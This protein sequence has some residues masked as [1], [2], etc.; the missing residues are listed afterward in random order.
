MSVP[1]SLS[2]GGIQVTLVSGGVH[3]VD[4]G[5]MM[6]ILP[7]GLWNKWYPADEENRIWLENHCLVVDT[8]GRRLLVESGCGNK[9]GE[10]ERRFYG[11]ENSDWI[12]ANLVSAGFALDSFDQVILTHLHTDH[13][14][15]VVTLDE[16]GCEVPTFPNAEVFVSRQELH[17]ANKGIGITPTAY[18]RR[19]WA[20]L[21]ER[22]KLISLP[23]DAQI[24]PSVRFVASPGH[25]N[26]H[27]SV[28]VEGTQDALLFTGELLPL[29][30]HAV[31]HYNM[32]FDVDPMIKTETKR[33]LLERACREGWILVL[34]HE[35]V[36]PV[37]RVVYRE[38]RGRYELEGV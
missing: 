6:G 14:G 3:L 27:Q 23:A 25:T 36:T 31:P 35:P 17:D 12:G 10:K 18:D 11:K 26:G 19:N 9:L 7:K 29:F 22:E 15:G 8:P 4:G 34:G 5:G 13:A 20:V 24:T 1:R 2:L 30:Y 21:E 16:K 38:E 37:C 33:R 32:A 28:L